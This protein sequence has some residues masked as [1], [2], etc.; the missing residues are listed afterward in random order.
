MA[1]KMTELVLGGA[2]LIGTELVNELRQ[3]GHDVVSLD[4]KTGHDLRQPIDLKLFEQC[5][6]VWFLA[7]DTGGQSFWKAEDRQ[8]EQYRNNCELQGIR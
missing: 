8:N 3:R 2:G 1:I 5:D 6:R 7:W 4:L